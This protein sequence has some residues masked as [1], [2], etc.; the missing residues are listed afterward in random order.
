MNC[1]KSLL[2]NS[3]IKTP[4]ELLE[5]EIES[6][7][8]F[9][10]SVP[11][12]QEEDKGEEKKQEKKDEVQNEGKKAFQELI[13]RKSNIDLSKYSERFFDFNNFYYLIPILLNHLGKLPKLLAKQ[14]V[15]LSYCN[16]FR[17]I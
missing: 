1:V 5:E 14:Q 4:D 2:E 7:F 12:E 9:E 17:V 10:L 13:K 15:S 16:H 11:A 6:N 8:G 3:F